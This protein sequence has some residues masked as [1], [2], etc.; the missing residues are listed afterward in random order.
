MHVRIS[1]ILP[2]ILLLYLLNPNVQAQSKSYGNF[3]ILV[4]AAR[5][6][7]D[8]NQDGKE[9]IFD[10]LKLLKVSGGTEDA[11]EAFDVNDDGK[12]NTFNLLRL[13]KVLSDYYDNLPL[14]LLYLLKI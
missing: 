8:V 1:I 10:P 14:N 11:S 12:I 13:L 3:L 4:A 5:P 7:G 2:F 9:D 6:D